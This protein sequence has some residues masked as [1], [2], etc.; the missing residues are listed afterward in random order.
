MINTFDC[1]VKPSSQLPS[2]LK[3]RFFPKL[4]PMTFL[5][6]SIPKQGYWG[7]H[8]W[9]I[10][11]SLTKTSPPREWLWQTQGHFL[12]P[13]RS[14]RSHSVCVCVSV[15]L[16]VCVSVCDIVEILALSSSFLLRSSSCHSSLSAVSQLSLSS[17]S[18]VSQQSL[19]CLSNTSS[20]CRSTK[21]FVLFYF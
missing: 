18:A 2:S 10:R 16:S 5:F 9:L 13:T 6:S 3:K 8:P 12:A 11:G 17:L 21:Y 7:L 4:V 1:I 19:S 15:C 20:Y 14:S